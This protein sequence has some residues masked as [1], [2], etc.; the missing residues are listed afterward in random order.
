MHILLVINQ[1]IPAKRYG[2]SERVVWDLGRELINSGHQVTFLAKEGSSCNFTKLIPFNTELTL[3]Q[4]IPE[5]VDVVHFNDHIGEAIDKPYVIT[6]HG[7]TNNPEHRMDRNSVF[8]SQDHARTMGSTSFV[9]N[10]LNWDEYPSPD[11]TTSRSYFHFLGKAAWRKKNIK[12]CIKTV[13]LAKQ[14]LRVMG[15]TRLNFKMGFRFTPYPSIQFEGMVDNTQKAHIMN[16]SKGLLFPVR[17]N[18]PFGLAITESLF[19]GCPVFGSPY[20]SLPELV[21][22]EV[23]FLS[24]SSADLAEQLK[25]AEQYS[26]QTCHEYARDLFNARVMADRY[27]EK[28]ETVLNGDFLNENPPRLLEAQTEKFLPFN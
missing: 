27:L 26:K 9:H 22:K 17:W 12:G 21:T 7:T 14:K 16:G 3:G 10:G 15:G 13:R 11:L 2:G 5:N 25:Q 19:F 28:Y 23:G 20:G 18:E 6:V 4:Q 24:A 8:V 1:I